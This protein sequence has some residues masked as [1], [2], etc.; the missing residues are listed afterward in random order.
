MLILYMR[1]VTF[2]RI[3]ILPKFAIGKKGEGIKTW[4]C[5]E[6]MIID[7]Y[8]SQNIN[9]L[10][11]INEFSKV[12]GYMVNPEKCFSIQAGWCSGKKMSYWAK[13][14]WYTSQAD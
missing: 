9:L 14:A 7:Y 8:T 1:N 12:V 5:T 11:V 13:Y 10:Q 3:S 4:I 2:K 6:G